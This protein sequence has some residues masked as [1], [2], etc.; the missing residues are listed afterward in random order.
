MVAVEPAVAGVEAVTVAAAVSAV[1]SVMALAITLGTALKGT[2]AEATVVVEVV[3]ITTAASAAVI[4]NATVVMDMVIRLRTAF[5]GKDALHSAVTTV[6]SE[7]AVRAHSLTDR[8][9]PGW[10]F[11]TRLS[12]GYY[13]GEGLL[14]MPT[15]GPYPGRLSQLIVG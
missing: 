15:A 6:C 3:V 10:S 1:I 4:N 13:G 11:L 2:E 12:S 8:R 5:K 9:W 7:I 14:Q